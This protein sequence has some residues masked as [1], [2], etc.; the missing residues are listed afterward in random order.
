MLTAFHYHNQEP[1]NQVQMD[2]EPYTLAL[3]PNNCIIAV[4]TSKG[5]Q[6]RDPLTFEFETA[7]HIASWTTAMAFLPHGS[8]LAV[9][10]QKNSIIIFKLPTGQVIAHR[11]YH[12][13]GITDL[14]FS[15]SSKFLVSTSI[16][17][18]C[19]LWLASNFSVYKVIQLGT[20]FANCIAF[21][22]DSRLVAGNRNSTIQVLDIELGVIDREIA[23]HGAEVTCIAINHDNS[24]IA[25]GGR[26]QNVKIFDV[27]SYS[28]LMNFCCESIVWKVTFYNAD[29]VLAAVDDRT[30]IVIEHGKLT[31]KF[32]Q[33]SLPHGIEVYPHRCK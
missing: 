24:R 31:K 14:A 15:P 28:C 10:G 18:S 20:S 19:V 33:H 16:D 11:K 23:E 9:N 21:I 12:K 32:S 2:A 30:V 25:S 8:V 3:S 27:S 5:V 17:K 26:D 1:S 6:I 13:E 22:D 4:G 7:L 29:T